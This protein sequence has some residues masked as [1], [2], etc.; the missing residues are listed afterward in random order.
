LQ[1]TEG[2]NPSLSAISEQ[3]RHRPPRP[4]SPDNGDALAL[5]FG[6]PVAVRWQPRRPGPL[7]QV[8]YD[9]FA[10]F[11]SGRHADWPYRSDYDP[12]ARWR[13]GD[14]NGY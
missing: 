3:H 4:A 8:E 11:R 10:E 14:G 5:T 2:S 12:Y 7:H 9:P 6:Y 13:N 1:G